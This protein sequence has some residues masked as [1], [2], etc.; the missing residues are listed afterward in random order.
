[1]SRIRISFLVFLVASI[2][3]SAISAEHAARSPKTNDLAARLDAFYRSDPFETTITN[4]LTRRI[5]ERKAE[6]F[7]IS[8]DLDPRL[9]ARSDGRRRLHDF[10]FLLSRHKEFAVLEYL[11]SALKDQ[12]AKRRVWDVVCGAGGEQA[13]ALLKRWALENPNELAL[14]SYHPDGVNLLLTQIENINAPLL[15]RTIAVRLLPEVADTNA[16]PRLQVF[17][18]DATVLHEPSAKPGSKLYTFADVIREC[19]DRLNGKK[20]SRN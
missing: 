11:E 4:L 9:I 5:E 3:L 20:P 10:L 18:N 7:R 13:K 15:D 1:M 8:K 2:G 19:I 14:M 17:A 12:E 16:I 6:C